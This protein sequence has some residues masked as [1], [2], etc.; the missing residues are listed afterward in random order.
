M[1]S[2][3]NHDGLFGGRSWAS[4]HTR[5]THMKTLKHSLALVLSLMLSP[6]VGIAGASGREVRPGQRRGLCRPATASRGPMSPARGFVLLLALLMATA[7]PR[8]A[9]ALAEYYLDPDYTGT[10]DG[11]QSQ[12]FSTLDGSA[13]STINAALTTDKVTLYCSAR[14]AGADTNQV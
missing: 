9:W 12:P 4:N 5:V 7:W 6:C 8:P 3:P 14:K 11:T 1:L 10:H 13:W 2:T